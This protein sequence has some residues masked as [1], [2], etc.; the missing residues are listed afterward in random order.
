[1]LVQHHDK[2]KEIE[3]RLSIFKMHWDFLSWKMELSKWIKLKKKK[4]SG[5]T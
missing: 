4:K 1:M 3:L 2:W 5:E